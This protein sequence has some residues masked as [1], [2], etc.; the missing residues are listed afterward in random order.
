MYELISEKCREIKISP[1]EVILGNKFSWRQQTSIEEDMEDVFLLEVRLIDRKLPEDQIL[2]QVAMACSMLL[3]VHYNL[4]FYNKKF[5]NTLSS[6]MSGI[7]AM[8]ENLVSK[9]FMLG[10][11]EIRV[12][13]L[14][15]WLFSRL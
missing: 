3:T 2:K 12:E 9:L 14:R 6:E 4:I 11:E 1:G 8:Y 13:E 5:P 15:D 10:S 7:I